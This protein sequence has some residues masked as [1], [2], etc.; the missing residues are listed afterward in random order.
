MQAGDALKEFIQPFDPSNE[1]RQPTDD[2][3]IDTLELFLDLNKAL[4]GRFQTEVKVIPVIDD[5]GAMV[6]AYEVSL[7]LKMSDG[8]YLHVVV[9][10]HNSE[11][12]LID[13]NIS[14][15]EHLPDGTHQSGHLYSFTGGEVKRSDLGIQQTDDPFEQRKH[16]S[17][18]ELHESKDYLRELEESDDPEM[19]KIALETRQDFEQDLENLDL[20]QAM[21]YNV[22]PVDGEEMRNL[23]LLLLDVES[24]PS[25]MFPE[26]NGDDTVY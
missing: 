4:L 12:A 20:A 3:L 22:Q 25:S 7:K 24:F 13:T 8:S 10:G 26:V 2:E 6:L 23:A 19:V 18:L 11:D 21:G 16:F 1:R 15:I 5:D 9:F 14:V 17:L